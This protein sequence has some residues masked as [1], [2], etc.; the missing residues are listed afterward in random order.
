MQLIIYQKKNSVELFER[1]SHFGGHS[2]T[3]N[4]S[5]QEKKQIAVDIGFIVFNENTYPNL[6]KFFHSFF[7]NFKINTAGKYS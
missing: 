2:H 3:I 7:K 1:E 6:I 4:I 5:Y